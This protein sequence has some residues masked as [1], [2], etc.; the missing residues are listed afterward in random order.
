MVHSP[1]M[2][3]ALPNHP[4]SGDGL[5]NFRFFECRIR[6]QCPLPAAAD[7]PCRSITK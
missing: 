3:N 6:S 5:E 7:D 1:P 4:A 2:T